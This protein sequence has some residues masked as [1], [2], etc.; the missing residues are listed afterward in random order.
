MGFFIKVFCVHLTEARA[1]ISG[2]PDKYIKSGSS[3]RLICE[4][5][6]STEEPDYVFW[7]Q[8]GLLEHSSLL[9]I[10]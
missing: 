9:C 4:L 2:G 10:C 8:V 3:L 7:Y 5:K 1:E 6:Q